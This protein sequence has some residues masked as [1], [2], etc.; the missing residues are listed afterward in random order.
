MLAA[1]GYT[2]V[3]ALP[4]ALRAF[5]QRL[6]IARVVIV[7]PSVYG[8]DNRATLY[9]IAALGKRAR[10][11]AVVANETSQEELR[12]FHRDGIR[13]IRLNLAGGQTSNA[14]ELSARLSRSIAQVAG[15]GWH[16]QVYTNIANV[17]AMV[18][19]IKASPVPIVF[20]HF[21][22]AQAELGPQQPGF[23]ALTELVASGRAYVKV[24][25]AYRASTKGPRYEDVRPLA[26]QLL[27]ANP[28]R[29]LWGTDWPH[30]NNTGPD[31]LR[32]RPG[33]PIDDQLL[34]Q[35]FAEWAPAPQLQQ[36]VLVENPARLYGF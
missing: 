2:P 6:G 28:A 33:L 13:G 5:H 34:L 20:D 26:R 21:G 19:T 12:Q 32:V 35:E 16:V 14:E 25:G 18:S 23:A 11:I 15:L 22:G 1:R 17:T 27:Q 10:G 29:V 31:P 3:P 24:S 36:K 7:T 4:S 30:P 9:G 8:T